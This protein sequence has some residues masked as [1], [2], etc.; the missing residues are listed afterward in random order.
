MVV[1]T[2]THGLILFS[3]YLSLT[4][5]RDLE[6]HVA[7]ISLF[8]GLDALISILLAGAIFAMFLKKI[9]AHGAE[10][11]RGRRRRLLMIAA[12]AATIWVPSVILD[13]LIRTERATTGYLPCREFSQMAGSSSAGGFGLTAEGCRQ[14][15]D[16]SMDLR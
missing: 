5:I 12:L 10:L 16:R 8:A 2:I 7:S 3:Q 1:L 4:K 13:Y 11:Q 9:A 6:G 14:A 15:N